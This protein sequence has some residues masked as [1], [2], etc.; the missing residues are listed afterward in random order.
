MEFSSRRASG[1]SAKINAL[2]ERALEAGLGRDRHRAEHLLHQLD[3]VLVGADIGAPINRA[4][5]SLAAGYFSA[6]GVPSD[7]HF[8]RAGLILKAVGSVV[9]DFG[10]I[11]EDVLSDFRSM[12]QSQPEAAKFLGLA[13]CLFHESTERLAAEALQG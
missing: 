8:V 4:L 3:G 1:Q 6:F 10:S 2:L 9:G 7:N 11:L 5:P 13:V 12:W